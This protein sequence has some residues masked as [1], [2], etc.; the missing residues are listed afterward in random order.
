MRQV[1]KI[2][3]F[4]SILLLGL[5][6]LV[7][8]ETAQAQ[9]SDGLGQI[10]P[11][12]QIETD[13]ENKGDYVAPDDESMLYLQTKIRVLESQVDAANHQIIALTTALSVLQNHHRELRGALL[14]AG[15]IRIEED[16]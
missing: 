2:G 13:L 6:A 4:L 7:N 5:A 15:V 14:D 1:L 16:S 10:L 12:T 3:G 9:S 8:T 11:K